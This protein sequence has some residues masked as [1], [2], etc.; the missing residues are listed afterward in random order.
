MQPIPQSNTR[1]NKRSRKL[2]SSKP[3]HL[4]RSRQSSTGWSPHHK[5]YR[6]K[7]THRVTNKTFNFEGDTQSC[8]FA[9]VP[10]ITADT[11]TAL[12]ANSANNAIKQQQLGSG[13]EHPNRRAVLHHREYEC[14]KAF[15]NNS[16]IS[17]NTYCHSQN[18][19]PPRGRSSNN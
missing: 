3:W 15:G 1:Q 11:S 4:K 18:T 13:N 2:T 16:D 7:T 10:K 6:Q 5:L 14:P 9:P 12:L 8:H 17:E 19:N